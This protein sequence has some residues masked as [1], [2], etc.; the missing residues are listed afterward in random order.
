MERLW[1][2]DYGSI[3]EDLSSMHETLDSVTS[4]SHIQ[5]ERPFC[6]IYLA[7]RRIVVGLGKGG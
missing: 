7:S 3:I 1:A 4:N 2:W 5:K 6:P